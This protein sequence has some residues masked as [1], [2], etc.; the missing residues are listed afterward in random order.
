MFLTS[1]HGVLSKMILHDDI[2][3]QELCDHVEF[4]WTQLPKITYE[5]WST[6]RLPSGFIKHGWL[7]NPRN[8]WMFY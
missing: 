6:D 3:G 4:W 1:K 7:E 5:T 8:E 2:I